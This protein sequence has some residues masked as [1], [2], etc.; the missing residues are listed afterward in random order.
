MAEFIWQDTIKIRT[1]EWTRGE[2]LAFW[3]RF[4]PGGDLAALSGGTLIDE[5]RLLEVVAAI[6]TA[7]VSVRK[8]KGWQP[9]SE[10]TEVEGLRLSW[11]VSEQDFAAMPM[12]LANGWINAAQEAVGSLT[13][14]LNFTL[15]PILTANG[16]SGS[17]IASDATP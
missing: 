17:A 6:S 2:L 15:R 12:S 13:T 11:P 7:S 16:T 4:M 9:I 10:D 3:G 14:L 8:G 1:R 5:E